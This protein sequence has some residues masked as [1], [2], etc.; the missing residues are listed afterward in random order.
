L[1]ESHVEK[2]RASYRRKRDAMLA[3]ADEH[4]ADLPGVSW[5]HPHGGLYVWMSLPDSVQTGFESPMFR[6]ATQ[7]ERVMY[8]PGEICYPGP[9]EQQ[10][11]HQ[12]R[13]SFGVET[14]ESIAE[15]I[16]R[17]ARAARAVL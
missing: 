3:A 14:P 12:M 5:V 17:L 2:V 16:E 4:F 11:R 15:G 1:Y 7:V 6:Q 10:A 8:V 9:I 13:L